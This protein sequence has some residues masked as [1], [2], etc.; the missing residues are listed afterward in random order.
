MVRGRRKKP[1]GDVA[2]HSVAVGAVEWELS[3]VAF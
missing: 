3:R 2:L 1:V